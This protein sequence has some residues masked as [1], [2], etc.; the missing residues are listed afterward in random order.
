M[1]EMKFKLK[2]DGKMTPDFLL[3]AI[4]KLTQKLGHVPSDSEMD[5]DKEFPSTRPFRRVFGSWGNALRA[6]GLEPQ[7]PRPSAKCLAAVSRAKKGKRSDNWKGG[8][9]VSNGYVLVYRP[10]HPNAT[11]KGYIREHRL[12]ASEILGRPLTP[13][14]DVHHGNAKKDDNSP[15][16]LEVKTKA[17]HTR[18]HHKGH[19]KKDRKTSHCKYPGGGKPATPVHHL[20]K[21][22]YKRQ[23]RRKQS[24]L[25][26]DIELIEDQAQGRVP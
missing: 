24:G 14:E 23:W 7:K 19:P 3:A 26:S 25:I 17:D 11:K 21:K 12:V 6:A 20:C 16:N 9:T 13:A 1:T 8:R 15:G 5:A 4:Q 18:F 10:D 22:H 2:K